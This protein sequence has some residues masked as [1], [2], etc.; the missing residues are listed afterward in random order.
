MTGPSIGTVLVTG[1]TGVFGRA[2]TKA[3]VRAGYE[4]VGLARSAGGP[5]P[6][7][8]TWAASDVRDPDAVRRAMAG[9]DAVVHL[10]WVVVPLRSADE[11]HAINLGGTTAVLDAM[12]ATGCDHLVFSSSLTAYGSDPD[13]PQ[14]YREDEP[15][16][17]DEAF[18]YGADKRRAELL[19][20]ERSAADGFT[21]TTFRASTVIGRGVTNSIAHVFAGPAVMGVA[22]ADLRWQFLH[23]DDLG[24][25]VAEAVRRRGTHVVNVAAP[26]ILDLEEIGTVLGKRVVEVPAAA[27]ARLAGPMWRLRL[28]EID[29]DSAASM[30]AMP[31]VDTTRLRDEWGFECAWSSAEAL[32]DARPTLDRMLQ[33]GA[34]TLRRPGRLPAADPDRPRDNRSTSG[35]ALVHAAPEEARGSLDT[36]IDPDYGTWTATNLSEAFPGPLTPLSLTLAIDTL[37]AGT[38]SISHLLGLE[39][40]VAHEAAVRMVGS[41]GHHLYVNV[42][43]ARESVRDVPGMSQAD[44]DA[45]YL[46][47][48]SDDR[49]RLPRWH[50]LRTVPRLVRR[51]VPALAGW[52]REVGRIAERVDGAIRGDSELDAMSEAELISHLDLLRD[53]M[54]EAWGAAIVGNFAT[55]LGS[56][57]D[58]DAVGVTELRSAA[59]LAGVESLVR[60]AR[61]EPE[62]V[63]LLSIEPS[64]DELR[65]AAPTFAI[66]FDELLAEVGH[67]GPGEMELANRPFADRPELLLGIVARAAAAPALR[68]PASA[69]AD[70]RPGRMARLALG[71]AATREQARDTA[72]VLQHAVRRTV[73]VLGAVLVE[74]DEVDRPDD[75]HFLTWEELVARTGDV[76]ELVERRRR[77]H[78]RLRALTMPVHFTGT[79]WSEGDPAR[80]GGDLLTG[81]AGSPGVVRGP[82]RI[83]RNPDDPMESGDVMVVRVTDVGWTP[84]FA[85]A[86]AVVTDIGGSLSHAAIVAREM[87]IPCVLGTE[88]AT[89]TLWDGQPVE[90]DGGAGTVH[91]L[92]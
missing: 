53:L 81:V 50:E 36:P 64:L 78:E 52:R 80:A 24:R 42:D 41:F 48:T 63:A 18:H 92:T 76:R 51:I 4:V 13:H 61:A 67:R 69:A 38:D 26:D 72:V 56:R 70:G 7:G 83:M 22:G 34:A 74:Q 10:A 6:R 2:A 65:R 47:T 73:R 90:V 40:P 25:F 79:W 14:P 30:T 60:A 59:A 91:I 46:G 9:C 32:A 68:S 43:V 11:I 3:L 33:L 49:R 77:E 82:V 54:A 28:T 75:L 15:L 62:L 23:P 57:D 88:H 58:V 39:G 29:P 45:Q 35:A 86:A 27:M 89:S 87:G 5:A 20:A 21:L 44:V 16:R 31:T 37:R 1:A 17:P 66:A 84:L 71:A 12:A 85:L 55:G 8:V 19:L